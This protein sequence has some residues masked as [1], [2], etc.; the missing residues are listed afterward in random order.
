MPQLTAVLVDSHPLFRTGLRQLLEADDI[1]VVGEAT[2]AEAGVHLVELHG[3]DVAIVDPDTPSPS[4]LRQLHAI[5]LMLE[6]APSTQLLVLAR[7]NA[8]HNA[9]D[10]VRL[11]GSCYLSKDAAAKTIL[12][13]VRAA[14]AGET[15]IAPT[16]ATA[17]VRRLRAIGSGEGPPP[18]SV[19]TG[20][21]QEVLRLI[22]AGRDNDQIAQDLF[23][24]RHTVK[25]HISSILLKLEVTNRVQAAVRATQ[26]AMM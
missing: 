15:L 21:E 24:S 26:E 8:A 16:V 14:A 23:I 6:R 10:V 18:H 5:R 17:L 1:A 4:G 19:L 12:A 7:A 2:T 11:G 13:G 9:V 25:N 22:A 20:R 3:P